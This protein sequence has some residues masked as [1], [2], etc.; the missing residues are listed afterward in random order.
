MGARGY[1]VEREATGHARHEAEVAMGRMR[2]EEG[3]GRTL[4]LAAAVSFPACNMSRIRVGR[5]RALK[6]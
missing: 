3:E 4:A 2:H 5:I 1:G 6:V